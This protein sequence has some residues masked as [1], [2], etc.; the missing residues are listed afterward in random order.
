MEFIIGKN[1]FPSEFLGKKKSA[2]LMVIT[3]WFNS[4]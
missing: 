3:S 4:S 2:A 1:E